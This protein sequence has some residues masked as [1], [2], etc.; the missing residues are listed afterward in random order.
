MAWPQIAPSLDIF[1]LFEHCRFIRIARCRGKVPERAYR[2]TINET[3]DFHSLLG[4]AFTGAGG[5]RSG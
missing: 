3:T 1:I 5:G 2:R 4:F